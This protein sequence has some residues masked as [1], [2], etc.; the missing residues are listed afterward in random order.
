MRPTSRIDGGI[1][2]CQIVRG[3]FEE[4]DRVI[5]TIGDSETVCCMIGPALNRSYPMEWLARAF[6]RWQHEAARDREEQE[7]LVES[8][9]LDRTI[10]RPPRL[11]ASTP[12]DRVQASSLLRIRLLSKICHTDLAA[13][14]CDE[15]QA[16]RFVR[17]R[18]FVKG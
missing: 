5:E 1:G 17:Q 18:I 13:F 11:T 15:V 10:V 6:A 14:I 12:K 2:N 8:S 7:R 3:N 16:G 4:L 9:R